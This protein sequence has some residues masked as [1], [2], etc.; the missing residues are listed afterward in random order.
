MRR[1]C[2]SPQHRA[3]GLEFDHVLILDAGGWQNAN[4]E[5]RRLYYVAMTRARLTLTLCA[6]HGYRH[7]FIRDCE[8]LCVKSRPKPKQNYIQQLGQRTW[9]ADPAQVVL[10]WPGYFAPDKPIHKAIAK[11]DY[12]SQL[13]LR[14]RGDGKAGWELTDM[15]GETV[16]R[17]AQAFIPPKGEIIEVRVSAILVRRRKPGEETLRCEYWEVILPEILYLG[18]SSSNQEMIEPTDIEG[19]I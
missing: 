4:D 13:T 5:E 2:C 18:P 19:I 17:M 10:S 15:D 7:H 8:D 16:S 11:L 3:K 1:S 14:K 9:V 12:G 6:R